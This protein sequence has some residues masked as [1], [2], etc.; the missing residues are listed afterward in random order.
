MTRQLLGIPFDT[1]QVFSAKNTTR[2]GIAVRLLTS[3]WVISFFAAIRRRLGSFHGDL[4]R[5]RTDLQWILDHLRHGRRLRDDSSW[6]KAKI[7]EF[8]IK[9]AQLRWLELFQTSRWQIWGAVKK[10]RSTMGSHFSRIWRFW[11]SK[12]DWKKVWRRIWTFVV[13]LRQL[14]RR[15]RHLL[16]FITIIYDRYRFAIWLSGHLSRNCD[17]L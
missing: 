3:G 12:S 10:I 7:R 2:Y 8:R 16:V 4:R 15:L 11:G 6:L 14:R 5:I 1:W 13:T 17:D 9:A